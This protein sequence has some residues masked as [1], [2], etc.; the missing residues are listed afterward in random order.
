MTSTYVNDLRLNEMATGDQSGSWGTVTNL[1]LELI[2]DAFGYGTRAIANASSDNITIADGT[3]DADRAMYLK[4]TGGG[5]ACTVTLLPN[6]VSKVWMMENGTS[7]ALTFTQGSGANVI[8]PAGDTKIIASDGAGSGAVVYDV[9]ASLSVVDLKVQDDLTVT[10]DMTVGGTLGV[11]GIATFTDDIIIGNGKTIGSAGDP[12]AIAISSGGVISVSATTASTSSTTGALTVGG[13][14]GVAADLFVGDDFDVAGDAVIDGTTLAT[15][16]LTATAKTVFNGGFGLPDSQKATFGGTGT[17][18]LQIF[19]DGSNSYVA[20]EGTGLLVLKTNGNAISLQ[21][22]DTE[23]MALFAVDGA[24]TLYHDNDAKI[25][26]KATGVTVTGEMASNTITTVS[27]AVIGST[28]SV[29]GTLSSGYNASITGGVPLN[30]VVTST[31][32]TIAY[33]G[34]GVTRN[35]TGVGQGTGIG[36]TMNS[37]DG[38]NREYAYIGTIIESNADGGAQDG[39]IGLFPVLN[40]ARAQRFTVKSS[41]D[42]QIN[43]GNLVVAD[44]HGID[45]S[46]TGDGGVTTTSELLDDYEEGTWT[47]TFTGSGATGVF[48]YSTQNGYY[49]KVGNIC[50]A[51]GFLV[52]NSV[53]SNFSGVLR[54]SG[55]PFTDQNLTNNYSSVN[56]GY[57]TSWATAAPQAGH[58]EPN[59]TYAIL[60]Y[61]GTAG[62]TSD[63]TAGIAAS[64]GII[65]S[66]TYRTA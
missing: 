43:D 37:A 39:S 51:H 66:I 4:L 26:T 20:D 42:C 40:N 7:A 44:G 28:L 57:S 33:G 48:G 5:Q 35:H 6:T 12:D 18:D 64:D 60:K 14:L 52:C 9:F 15:G 47:P 27:G 13:G 21:K 29:G 59:Q 54:I 3:A 11:T 8:I 23:T 1:N 55:L 61:Y 24:A 10:D 46:A 65:F 41:G 49:E 56:I 58:T 25:A 62:N 31:V 45:F 50:H 16:I 2:G 22:G 34:L 63:L 53:T 17:G 36:F 38:T 32:S 30:T 19:H